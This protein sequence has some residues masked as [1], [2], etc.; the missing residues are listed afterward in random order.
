MAELGQRGEGKEQKVGLGC[1][2]PKKTS[3]TYLQICNERG[4]RAAMEAKIQTPSPIPPPTFLMPL[5][6]LSQ[7]N[8]VFSQMGKL[9]GPPRPH[10]NLLSC[11]LTPFP[12]IHARGPGCAL[13]P[14]PTAR[15]ML[16]I[17][18]ATCWKSG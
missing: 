4:P 3:H 8:L 11:H 7:S 17:L 9:R 12:T 1:R 14:T 2:S 18:L 15:L 6:P 13:L 16:S 10:P 5:T